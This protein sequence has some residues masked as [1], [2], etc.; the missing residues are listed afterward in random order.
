MALLVRPEPRGLDVLLIKRAMAAGDPWS[1]HMALPGGRR[2]AEDESRRQTAL[3]E[4]REEVGIEIPA[5]DAFLGRLD[6]VR[7]GSGAPQILVSPF[8]FAVPPATEARTNYEVER[9]LW[10]PL[11][12][13]L[14]PAAATEYLHLLGNGIHMRFP[15]LAYRE[16]II[17]GL[18]HRILSQFI[19]V[20][21]S[22]PSVDRRDA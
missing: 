9:A 18:T 11:D 12:H 7:P 8:V 10:V 21:R 17:W 20:A 5:S 1:G 22:I 15:A 14:A 3:R 2:A 19:D 13:L 4:T 6:D 16:H